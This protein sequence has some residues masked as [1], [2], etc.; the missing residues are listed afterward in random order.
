MNVDCHITDNSILFNL[1]F[2]YA[3][4][5]GTAISQEKQNI[6]FLFH[7]NHWYKTIRG[8]I[9]LLGGFLLGKAGYSTTKTFKRIAQ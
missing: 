9:R 6:I 3:D 8:R 7:P 5:L 2:S 4:T 1:G